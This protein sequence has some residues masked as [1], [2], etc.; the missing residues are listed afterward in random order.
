[1]Q[2]REYAAIESSMEDEM[3]DAPTITQAIDSRHELAR[4]TV[5]ELKRLG[6]DTVKDTEFPLDS[7]IVAAWHRCFSDRTPQLIFKTFLSQTRTFQEGRRIACGVLWYEFS[8][9]SVWYLCQSAAKS[10]DAVKRHYIIQYAFEELGMRDVDEIHSELLKKCAISS[11]IKE[12]AFEELKDWKPLHNELTNLRE[13]LLHYSM[14]AEV[15]GL[16]LGM[17][18]PAR[19]NISTVQIC[20]SP[21]PISA[22]IIL[23]SRFFQIHNV[24]EAEHIRLGIANFLRFCPREDDKIG[25]LTG[26]DDGIRFWVGFWT[27][28]SQLAQQ[29]RLN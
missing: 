4:K 21:D 23:Q 20:L 25:F 27:V 16:N 26:F 22:K 3:T 12:T 7:P 19:E 15:L 6:Y 8:K 1:M 2:E 24:I 5:A 10:S 29:L 28:V 18:F 11:G 14:D 17:E 13:I 9:F